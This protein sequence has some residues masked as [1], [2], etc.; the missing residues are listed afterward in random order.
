MFDRWQ[1]SLDLRSEFHRLQDEMDRLFGRWG[2][3]PRSPLGR[4][5]FP[6]VNLWED[7]S[8]VYLET[9]LPG[10]EMSDLEILVSGGNQLSIKGE[11]KQP[12]STNGTWHR[13]ERGFGSFGRVIELPSPVDSEAVNATFTHGVLLVTL[14]KREEAKPRRIEVK[15]V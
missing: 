6:P 8:N 10:L 9:E 4:S 3:N 15:S 1:P 11:R 13:Q 5:L 2:V 7:A 12:D 14:P